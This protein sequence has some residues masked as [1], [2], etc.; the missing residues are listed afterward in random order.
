MLPGNF[1]LIISDE[2]LFI[3]NQII[4]VIDSRWRAITNNNLLSFQFSWSDLSHSTKI[5]D[6]WKILNHL[7]RENVLGHS[8]WH[9]QS[10]NATL[11]PHRHITLVATSNRIRFIRAYPLWFI[12][13]QWTIFASPGD[14]LTTPHLFFINHSKDKTK[15][16]CFKLLP[17]ATH[18]ID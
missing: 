9:K 3:R 6:L 4:Q 1:Q 13:S 15:S 2:T 17:S 5:K 12:I 8:E 18:N 7:S 16:W 10:N 14:M 11:W